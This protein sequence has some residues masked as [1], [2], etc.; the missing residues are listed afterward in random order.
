MAEA[1]RESDLCAKSEYS[2]GS[3][4]CADAGGLAAVALF[5][6]LLLK[7]YVVATAIRKGRF[8]PAAAKHCFV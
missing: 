3:L 6:R 1:F 5:D 4:R 7:S 8:V 2:P